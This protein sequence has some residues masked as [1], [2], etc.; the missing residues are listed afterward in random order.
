M[1]ALILYCN[2][3]FRQ[4]NLHYIR[5]TKNK[6][7]LVF[8]KYYLKHIADMESKTISDVTSIC[9]NTCT[10]PVGHTGDDIAYPGP[11]NLLAFTLKCKANFLENYKCSLIFGSAYISFFIG[12]DKEIF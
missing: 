8:Q 2:R 1:F 12:P 10:T 3:C 6:G 5:R 7:T 11:L 9:S 4:K